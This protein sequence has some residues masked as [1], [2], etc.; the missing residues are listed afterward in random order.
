MPNPPLSVAFDTGPLHGAKT[1]I[2][3]AVEQLRAALMARSD[4]VMHDY[5]LSFRARLHPDTVRL[6]IPASL[7]H[8]AWA[9]APRPTVDRWLPMV[10]V[11]HGTNYVAPPTQLPTVV[12][13]YDCWFLRHPGDATPTVRRAGDV[14]R[15][16]I[17]RGAVVHTSSHA[18]E[19]LMRSLFPQA[20]VRTVHLGPLPL[21]PPSPT[22]PIPTLVGR[23]FVLSIGT[24][25]RRKNL[26]R[27]VA[28]FGRL[29]A[30][31][32]DIVLVLAGGA[33]DDSEAVR[34]AID[35]LGPALSGRVM[36][37]G[38]VD[39]GARSWLLRHAAVL[40]YPSL[41]EGFGFP[42]LDA[43]QAGTPVVASTAGSIPEVSGDAALLCDALDV[44]GLAEGLALA[45][46]DT[47]VRARLIAAGN[48]QWTR[49]DWQH[50]AEGIA[51]LYGL[52]V[53][54]ATDQLR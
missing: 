40:A 38:R 20:P 33:G 31:H 29:A 52:A 45:V 17:G 35:A 26:P 28:A 48:E 41:D 49:F 1:G 15:A 10:D 21:P 16:A 51:D 18:T 27:L 25:E 12:S 47:A 34:H 5:V 7:A 42:L 8:R 22:A 23:P 39:D 53:R 43:M 50:C 46:A 37:T 24:L 36:R 19:E 44:D 30:A 14:L 4:L 13:V 9:R 32:S 2:G 11:V 54:G 3:F 6:P